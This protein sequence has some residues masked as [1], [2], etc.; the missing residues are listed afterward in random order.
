MELKFIEVNIPREVIKQYLDKKFQQDVELISFDRLGTGWHSTG[1][2]IVCKINNENK[3]MILRT[4]RKEG[5][6]HEYPSDRARVFIMQHDL[7]SKIPNHV[8]SID[9][10]GF[11]KSGALVSIG[12]CNEFF[13]IVEL[14]QGIEYF[15]DFEKIKETGTITDEDRKKALILSDYLVELHNMKFFDLELDTEQKNSMA[16]SIHRRHTRDAVGHGEML[17]GVLDTYPDNLPWVSKEELLDIQVKALRLRDRIKD[18]HNRLCRMHGDFHPG[19]ILFSSAE[20]FSVLDASREF[21]GEPAD[22]LTALGINYILYAVMQSGNFSGPFAEL[23]R[24]FW[25]NYMNKTQDFDSNKIAPLFFAFRGIVVCH[26]TFF[27]YPDQLRRKMFNFIN[28]LIEAEFFDYNK[29]NEYMG[30]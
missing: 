20:H 9:V 14:A 23:F 22:D 27:N 5:F 29:I 10:G 25:D 6:S 26:P 2:K 13:Q 30:D 8:K 3:T 11:D 15:H 7:S 1:Y 28:K 16:S 17:M 19:N 4:V 21:W 12:R 18:L 24:M